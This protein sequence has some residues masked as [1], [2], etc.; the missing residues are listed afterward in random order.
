MYGIKNVGLASTIGTTETIE[1]FG[2]LKK[3]IPVVFKIDG[4]QKFQLHLLIYNGLNLVRLAEQA[5]TFA[6][7]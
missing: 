7:C 1:V 4:F 5:Y 6:K 3:K 2:E